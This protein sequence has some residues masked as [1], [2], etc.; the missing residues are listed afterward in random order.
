MAISVLHQPLDG[1]P[2]PKSKRP[3][4]FFAKG[5]WIRPRLEQLEDRICPTGPAL[6]ENPLQPPVLPTQTGVTANNLTVPQPSSSSIQTPTSL[7]PNSVGA[8]DQLFAS[9]D[10]LTQDTPLPA[11]PAGPQASALDQA[12][13]TDALAAPAGHN[14]HLTPG[15]GVDGSLVLGSTD[16]VTGNGTVSG[17]VVSSGVVSPGNS[18]GIQQFASYSQTATGTLVVQ[19]YGK[20]AAG[21]GDGYD[22]LQVAGAA[23]LNGTLQVQLGNNFQP[24]V[25]DTFPFLT[26]GSVTG[27][28]TKFQGLG[29]GNGLYFKPQL[30][31]VNKVYNLVVAEVPGQAEV[32]GSELDLTSNPAN[33]G[34]TSSVSTTDPGIAITA[35]PSATAFTSATLTIS[36]AVNAGHVWSVLLDGQT[37]S[38]TSVAGDTPGTVAQQL[39]KAISAGAF[40][41]GGHGGTASVASNFF[42]FLAGRITT[43]V[44][45]GG[46]LNVLGQSLSGQWT[47]SASTQQGFDFTL[48]GTQLQATLTDG[49]NTLLSLTAPQGA[50]NG[51]T[52]TFQL[53]SSGFA[54]TGSFG[55]NVAVGGAALSGTYTLS[56]N[57]A[58]TSLLNLPAGPYFQLAAT[59]QTLTLPLPGATGQTQTLTG[60]FTLQA[61]TTATGAQVVSVAL[62]NA[63][64]NLQDANHNGINVQSGQGAFILDSN[65]VAGS[66]SGS[67]TLT[68]GGAAGVSL[69]ATTVQVQFNTES[70]AIHQTFTVG[71]QSVQV[72]VPA[73]PHIQ[74]VA[75]NAQL[76]VGGQVLQGD[77]FVDQIQGTGTSTGSVTRIA[78]ANL[79]ATVGTQGR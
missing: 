4:P 79:A 34:G 62:A 14:Y 57:T 69:L 74:V 27:D 23:S 13:A 43:P 10:W 67:P 19:V 76:T 16:E 64:L 30:D 50:A 78:V 46:T 1:Q 33:P 18:P 3:L 21:A 20:G 53:G 66:F 61:V 77:F 29:I 22:Q 8:V 11:A 65:G 45:F 70:A 73:G 32:Q 58:S 15:G 60:D 72:N 56:V 68:I 54:G 42:A 37:Y 47:V 55:L 44:T 26:F 59:G 2:P 24:A 31:P 38:Y 9:G 41:G 49:S 7:P 6:P 36:G 48:A 17:P 28:F 71:G 75:R 12:F 35:T 63:S 52:A 51:A 5:E 40:A 25:G 39:G